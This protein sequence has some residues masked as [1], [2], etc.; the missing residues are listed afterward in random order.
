MGMVGHDGMILSEGTGS[1]SSC[2]SGAF[3]AR[4]HWAWGRPATVRGRVLT[5][6]WPPRERDLCLARFDLKVDQTLGFRTAWA[7]GLR[8]CVLRAACTA[9][10]AVEAAPRAVKT[11]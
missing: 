3:P 6:D 9:A 4:N 1:L 7:R 11:L 2:Q 10:V 5:Q 8:G